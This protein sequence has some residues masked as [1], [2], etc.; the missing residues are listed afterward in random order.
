MNKTKE[1]NMTLGTLLLGIGVFIL[2][3]WLLKVIMAT[4]LNVAES[5][6]TTGFYIVLFYIIAV[7]ALSIYSHFNPK[8]TPKFVKIALA[9]HHTI[10]MVIKYSFKLIRSIF[11]KSKASR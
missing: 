9:F 2:V 11:R 10:A 1:D 3:I 4:L 5:I 6:L 7:I 8:K